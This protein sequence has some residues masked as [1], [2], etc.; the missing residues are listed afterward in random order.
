[1]YAYGE[2][3]IVRADDNAAYPDL[4]SLKGQVVGVQAG[5]IFTTN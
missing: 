5:T 3:L 1:V 2:G 4:T